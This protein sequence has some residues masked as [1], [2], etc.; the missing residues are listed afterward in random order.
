MKR[1]TSIIWSISKEDLQKIVYSCSTI[2]EILNYFEL[3]N[4]GCNYR[5]LK[6][7]FEIDNID[8]AH[9]A[10]GLAWAK[11]EIIP[12]QKVSLETVLVE[13]S[14]FN[15]GHLKKRLL[16]EGILKNVCAICGQLPE[17]NNKPLVLQ[18]DHINGISD[19]NRLENLRILCPHCHSQT[20]TFA[21][22]S[23][24][25]EKSHGICIVCN[26]SI[27]YNR[28]YCVDCFNQSRLSL[29]K[30]FSKKKIGKNKIE[31][32]ENEK[33]ISLVK[34]NG[35]VKVGKMLGVSN[36]AIKKRLKALNLLHCLK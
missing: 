10:N 32:P 6:K 36:N 35:F 20:E 7:R 31:Y 22:K 33:L 28:K 30:E 1:R 24:R 19:D 12:R 29:L 8:R 17:W 11:G 9:I 15:R 27:K 14:S 25:K 3:Q 2:R 16:N 13:N 4:K 26:V 21:G 34:E 23:L 18:L 5:S